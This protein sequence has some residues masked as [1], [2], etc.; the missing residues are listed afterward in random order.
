MGHDETWTAESH[1]RR[2]RAQLQ[3]YLIQ[4]DM[5]VLS[6]HVDLKQD[7]PMSWVN[8]EPVSILSHWEV[9]TCQS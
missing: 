5:F 4:F 2:T 6:L 8:L 9:V 1:Y 7:L 3:T